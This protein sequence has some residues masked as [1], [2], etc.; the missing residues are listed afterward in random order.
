MATMSATTRQAEGGMTFHEW[1]K[2]RRAQQRQVTAR[3]QMDMW[4]TIPAAY[5]AAEKMLELATEE[6]KEIEQ[7]VEA[8]ADADEITAMR[9]GG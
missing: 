8:R 7:A 1:G 4:Q 3:R 2:L 5:T 9:H 6:I